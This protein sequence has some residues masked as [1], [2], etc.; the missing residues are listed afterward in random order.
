MHESVRPLRHRLFAR[1]MVVRC[2]ELDRSARISAR[3]RRVKWNAA[4]S[5]PRRSA[6]SALKLR[7]LRAGIAPNISSTLVRNAPTCA[8]GWPARV[9]QLPLRIVVASRNR[10]PH[11]GL[12][13]ECIMA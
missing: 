13:L 3:S 12:G 6:R 7:R 9:H 11:G 5:L 4:P 10:E 2:I 8:E 1:T